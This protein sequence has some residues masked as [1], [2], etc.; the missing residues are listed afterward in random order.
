M[1]TVQTTPG[2]YR[3]ASYREQLR[4]KIRQAVHRE[5]RGMSQE[6][7]KRLA[8]DFRFIANQIFPERFD[9]PE[10]HNPILRSN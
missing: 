6:Q 10:N 5:T 1:K 8:A 9:P 2:P 7:I 3:Q 4:K